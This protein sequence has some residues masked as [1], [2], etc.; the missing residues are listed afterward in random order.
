MVVCQMLQKWL[1]ENRDEDTL[2][3][4]SRR[5]DPEAF[6]A[7]I[8]RYQKMIHALTYRMSGS[9]AD[10]E[11]LAQETF[12]LAWRRLDGF[13]G[14]AKFSSWLYRIAVNQCLNWRS[15]QTR[16]LRAREEW[17]GHEPSH[18]PPPDDAPAGAV[19]KALL[20]LPAKQ[21]AALVLTT[22]DGLSHAEAARLLNC[23]E[24]TVSW[25]LFAART[26]LKLWLRDFAP[27]PRQTQ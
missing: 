12:V 1:M 11:D 4:A 17:D 7:L 25:R 26:K 23:S 2:I 18:V 13:R 14:D 21:R 15:S 20:R 8:C 5:G 27:R 16:E 10:A 6:A 3:E 19:Q 24:T 22:C 9:V